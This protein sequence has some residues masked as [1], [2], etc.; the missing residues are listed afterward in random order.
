[1]LIGIETKFVF[2]FYSIS[3]LANAKAKEN[4]V[5]DMDMKEIQTTMKIAELHKPQKYNTNRKQK[6][7]TLKRKQAAQSQSIS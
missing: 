3:Q 1:M 2:W 7:T 6:I 4:D 5:Y